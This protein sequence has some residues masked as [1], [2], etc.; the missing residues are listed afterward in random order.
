M[1]DVKE[2][3]VS[4][5]FRIE[6]NSTEISKRTRNRTQHPMIPLLTVIGAILQPIVT[7]I[8]QYNFPK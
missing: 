1:K 2:Y 6:T 3:K 8:L 4:F 7:A 5:G